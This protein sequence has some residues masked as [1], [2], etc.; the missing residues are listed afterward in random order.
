MPN[1]IEFKQVEKNARIRDLEMEN[2]K[3]KKDHNEVSKVE[4]E[5]AME[6]MAKATGKELYIGTKKSLHSKVR[7]AQI[8]QSNYEFLREREYLT[9]KEKTFL[10]DIVSS[11]AFNSNCIVDDVKSKNPVPLNIS[12][13]AKKI[14]LTRANTSLSVN[15]LVKKGILAKAESGIDGNNAKAYS[16]FVNPHIIYAGDKDNVNEALKAIF[17]KSMKMKILKDLPDK[18]F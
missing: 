1:T 14:G 3:F 6:T 10:I 8:L 11:I 12:G 18:L 17:Y 5:K 13:L 4:L 9:A 2:E 7:F 16:L 15:S